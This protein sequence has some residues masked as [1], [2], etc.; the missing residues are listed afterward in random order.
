LQRRGLPVQHVLA[1]PSHPN[2][3]CRSQRAI[4]DV[5]RSSANA[6]TVCS[7]TTDWLAGSEFA[8]VVK[9][10]HSLHRLGGFVDAAD[11][12]ADVPAAVV[13]REYLAEVTVL[14][15]SSADSA[16]QSGPRTRAGE[17]AQGDTWLRGSLGQ[18]RH[19]R[20]LHRHVLRRALPPDRPAPQ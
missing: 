5:G 14:T 7:T 18:D 10:V 12:Y 8:L 15:E 2:P 3:A 13:V 11:R 9:S 19:R 16:R 17:K 20:R 6:T 4:E 1:E